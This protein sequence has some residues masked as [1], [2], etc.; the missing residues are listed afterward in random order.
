MNE[1]DEFQRA[2]SEWKYK[3]RLG[4]DD[5]VL[6]AMELMQLFFKN[7]KIELPADS[8]AVTMMEVRSAIHQLN[9]LAGDFSK[10]TREVIVEL[11]DVP[12]IRKGLF[13]GRVTALVFTA[14]SAAIAGI[15]IGKYLL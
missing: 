4:D 8:K 5:P 1:A 9:E 12:N 13:A 10:Q 6:A 7:V 2:V 3:H 14:I 11:R 15:F